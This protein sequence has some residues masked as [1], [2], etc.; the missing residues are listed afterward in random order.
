MSVSL[1]FTV[2]VVTPDV[3]T[4]STTTL[5]VPDSTLVSFDSREL[6]L[7]SVVSFLA[8]CADLLPSTFVSRAEILDLTSVSSY[9]VSLSSLLSSASNLESV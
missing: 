7:P 1:T 2:Y 8:S 3:D 9:T 4:F 5:S 6:S